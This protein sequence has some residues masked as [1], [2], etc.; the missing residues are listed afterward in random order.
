MKTETEQL[1]CQFDL[2]LSGKK[3]AMLKN[4]LPKKECGFCGSITQHSYSGKI[5]LVCGIANDSH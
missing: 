4:E 5:C 2:K 1:N 3:L